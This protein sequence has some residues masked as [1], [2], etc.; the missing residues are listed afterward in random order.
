MTDIFEG[1]YQSEALH[2]YYNFPPMIARV[3]VCDVMCVSRECDSLHS[4]TGGADSA[5]VSSG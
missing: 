1:E 5:D 3:C 2:V 4:E